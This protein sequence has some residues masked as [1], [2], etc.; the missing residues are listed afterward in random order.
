MPERTLRMV[1]TDYGHTRELDVQ[2]MRQNG[3]NL[4]KVEVNPIVAAYRSMVRDL[5][6][7]ICELAPATYIA[8]RAA[9]AAL[10][11]I[12]AFVNRN[13]HHGDLV[14]RQGSGILNPKDL[15]GKKVGVRAY[16]V[17]TGVWI[18]GMLA[19]EY[20]VDLNKITWVVDDEE[21]VKEL[22]LPE[23][24]VH[25]RENTSLSEMFRNGDL[26][27]AV[28]GAA[29][30][31][32]TGA[33]A[34]DW[35]KGGVVRAEYNEI[36]K[37]AEVL[38][39]KR[40]K[41]NHIYPIHGIVVMRRDVALHYPWL[42][43]VLYRE[44]KQAKEVYLSG[45]E[46]KKNWTQSDEKILWLKKITGADPIPY[47]LEKNRETLEALTRY[48]FEQK[49]TKRKFQVEELFEDVGGE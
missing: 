16:S 10:V 20:G 18:R 4:E 24:V 17:S 39:Q 35:E 29:G 5:K 6:Y 14:S 48:C 7:D 9:G 2:P 37:D 43:K 45:L 31:G 42:P 49:I 3:V 27:A 38:D 23:N 1:I 44:L 46:S 25:V 47:G 40:Y 22:A 21:H 32:R 12:P 26:D 33:A 13:F 28:K 34:K 19:D 30:I 11:A 8:A 15:E 41:E 36:I